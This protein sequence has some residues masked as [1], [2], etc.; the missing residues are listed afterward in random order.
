MI[1][2]V[3]LAEVP[4]SAPSI[5]NTSINWLTGQ[6]DSGRLEILRQ[7]PRQVVFSGTYGQ[8]HE[9][10]IDN[11]VSSTQVMDGVTLGTLRDES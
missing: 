11:I 1:V 5:V 7:E 10:W 9:G 3:M 4:I 2:L 6:A 8:N